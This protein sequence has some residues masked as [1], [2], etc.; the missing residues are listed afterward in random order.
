[1]VLLPSSLHAFLLSKNI[2]LKYSSH[3]LPIIETY[4]LYNLPSHFTILIHYCRPHNP[5]ILHVIVRSIPVG[6][7]IQSSAL[8][9][10]PSIIPRRKTSFHAVLVFAE[11]VICVAV[12]HFP[13]TPSLR[14]FTTAHSLSTTICST[15]GTG[16]ETSTALSGVSTL[17]M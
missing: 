5:R 9:I 11:T 2:T 7:Q 1:M 10:K 13:L 15:M 6:V 8:L 3:L 17:S 12:T 14:Q 4:D 16:N